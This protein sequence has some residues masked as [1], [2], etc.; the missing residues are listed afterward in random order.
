MANI[1]NSLERSKQNREQSNKYKESLENSEWFGIIVS[2]DDS[3]NYDGRCKVRVFEKFDDI[4]DEDLPWAYPASNHV[5]AGGSNKGA[6]SFSY[7]VVGTIVRVKFNNGDIYHPEY[8]FIQN[9]NTKMVSEIKQ[10]YINSNVI[11]YL[12]DCDV[13]IMYTDGV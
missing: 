6:G 12:E 4:P 8:F 13:K 10:S 7:P 5:F 9:L 11:L 1:F 2:S 3:K